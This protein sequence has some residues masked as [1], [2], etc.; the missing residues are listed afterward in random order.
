M[1]GLTDSRWLLPRAVVASRRVVATCVVAAVVASSLSACGDSGRSVKLSPLEALQMASKQPT[2]VNVYFC[3]AVA[4]PGCMHA[5]SP[6]E[7]QNAERYVRHAHC[8][9][10]V[11]F[12]PSEA[13]ERW[14]Q[15]EYNYFFNNGQPPGALPDA[16]VI[17]PSNPS[18]ST[19]VAVSIRNAHLP[20][21]AN[22]TRA[23][24]AVS[25]RR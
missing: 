4:V 3:G 5:A 14:V 12:I 19:S 20:G 18:C 6:T 9:R 2:W 1:S 11:T 15:K 21:V 10:R 13:G 16:L 23:A 8:V 22:V 17:E 7:Q 25:R 24:R